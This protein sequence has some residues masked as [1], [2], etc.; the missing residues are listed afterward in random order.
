MLVH[1]RFDTRTGMTTSYHQD[2]VTDAVTI[3][4]C[5]DVEAI[6]DH[7]KA[8]ATHDDG[9]SADRGLRRAASIPLAVV[10]KWMTEYGVDVLDPEHGP[11]VK[12]LLNSNEWAHL[13][14]APGR[15]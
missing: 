13:R 14:T 8:L 2:A 4:R 9:Y 1:S 5:Q 15:L 6:L 7:N 3:A 12:K 10:E 11:A